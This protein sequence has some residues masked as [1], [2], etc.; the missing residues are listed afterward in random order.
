MKDEQVSVLSQVLPSV[1]LTIPSWYKQR[2]IELTYQKQ[3]LLIV[4]LSCVLD[5]Q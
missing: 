2:W 3:V 4:H 1:W 5:T